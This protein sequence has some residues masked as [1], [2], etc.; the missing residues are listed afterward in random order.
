MFLLLNGSFGIGK[1]T[2][3]E[4]L[5]QELPSTAIS[6]PEAVGY[7]LRRLPAFMVGLRRQP[8]DYQ[9]MALW[10]RII[11]HQARWVH[12]RAEIVIVPMAFTNRAYLAAFADALQATAPVQRMCLVAPLAVIRARLALRAA[13]EGRSGLTPFEL[14]RSAECAAAHADPFFGTPVDATG[15]IE[16]VVAT[17]RQ[18]MCR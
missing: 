15:D 3:A 6:D 2:A 8:G 11:V 1:T 9:D 12:R 10:R 13:E 18:K 14:T 5:A 7:L 17:I 16:Q 4:R